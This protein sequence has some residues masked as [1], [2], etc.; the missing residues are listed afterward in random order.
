MVL[1]ELN[2]LI[3]SNPDSRELKRAVA[4]QMYLK[5]YK[6]R[7]IQTIL[8]VSS[9]FISKWTDQYRQSG[10]KGLKLGYMGSVGYLKR[11]QRQEVID[12]LQEKTY[13][14]LPEVQRYI[15]DHY[16]VLFKSKQS[17]YSLFSEARISWKKTQ[18]RN[19]K[20]DPNLVAKKKKEI[21]QWLES[22]R[23]EIITG[24]LAVFYQDECHLLWGD[25]CGYVWGKM[26]ER[27]EIPVSNEKMKQTYYG[28]VN[29]NN[30]ECLVQSYEKGNS[31]NTIKFIKYLLSQNPQSRIALIW[32]GASYHRS[33]ELKEYLESVNQGKP[34]SQ[35]KVTC[36]RFAPNCPRQNPMEDIWLEGKKFIREFYHLCTS[37]KI[38]KYLFEFVTHKQI[39]NFPKLFMYG[40]FSQMI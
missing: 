33:Q 2:Q 23:K 1:D 7:Y 12:W 6:H 24:E 28:A 13:Y 27:I 4:V 38:V 25:I 10:V 19:P 9:G 3:Q 30:Q 37:F 20:E 29:I 26:G 21:T 32:D 36:I 22:Q 11:K 14:Y 5:G 34:E 40:K 18:K 17:Y 15:E 31:E 8:G 35:W 39:F 16:N